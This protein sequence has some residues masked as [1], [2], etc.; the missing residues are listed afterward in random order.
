MAKTGKMPDIPKELKQVNAEEFIYLLK[1]YGIRMRKIEQQM[2]YKNTFHYYSRR[3]R[4][5]LRYIRALIDLVKDDIGVISEYLEEYRA[6][7]IE[8][9]KKY[10]ELIEQ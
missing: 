10:K 5:P 3:P 7:V 1:V 8:Q 2:G 6:Y 9:K 4:L